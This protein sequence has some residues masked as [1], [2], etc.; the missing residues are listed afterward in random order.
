MEMKWGSGENEGGRQQ[1]RESAREMAGE[2]ILQCPPGTFQKV[3]VRLKKLRKQSG[4]RAPLDGS[5]R[6]SPR[7]PCL[8]LRWWV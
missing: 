5:P 8:L 2:V 1:R 6:V 7:V 4:G 3:W